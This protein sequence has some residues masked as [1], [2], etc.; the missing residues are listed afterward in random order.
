MKIGSHE[1]HPLADVFPLMDEQALATLADD[2]RDNGL[3]MSVTLTQDGRILDGRNRYLACLRVG[4][5]PRFITYDH[6]D[7]GLMASYVASK[8]LQRRDLDPG[9]RALCARR[10]LALCRRRS[11][12][13]QPSLPG[14]PEAD[15]TAA[16]ALDDATPELLE[17][18]T[19]GDIPLAI[20]AQVA[21]MPD[22]E[23]RAFVE[24]ARVVRTRA[25]ELSPQ[26]LENLR[27]GYDS[28][29]SHPATTVIERMV[30]GL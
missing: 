11:P 23:Q 30:P 6:D 1:T 20:A 13:K 12:R 4:V 5:E 15:S 29:G 24:K 8:N 16:A 25:V 2:I 18:T 9:Q 19:R 10:L 21:A 17:A 28:L 3:L 26:E 27:D 14:V 22:D 7:V